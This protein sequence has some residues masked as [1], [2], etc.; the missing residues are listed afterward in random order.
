MDTE[1]YILSGFFEQIMRLRVI[2]G[3]L[4]RFTRIFERNYIW[5]NYIMSEGT[6]S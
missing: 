1:Y 5:I 2:N 3:R 4:I 6:I